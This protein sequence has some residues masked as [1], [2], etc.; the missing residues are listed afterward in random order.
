MSEPTIGKVELLS[1]KPGDVLFFSFGTSLLNTEQARQVR[2][3][4]RAE[5]D[6]VGI[7]N[8]FIM[9]DGGITLQSVRPG[10]APDP[11]TLTAEILMQAQR[12]ARR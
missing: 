3:H 8:D 6:R 9:L 11:S 12:E 4:I 2:A 7:Q 1:A 10:P 5:L